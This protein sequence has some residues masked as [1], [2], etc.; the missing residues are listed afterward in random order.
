M[1]VTDAHISAIRVRQRLFGWSMRKLAREA[2][3]SVAN[4]HHMLKG[5]YAESKR[6]GG[7]LL[8]LGIRPQAERTE[9]LAD[10]R[11][12]TELARLMRAGKSAEVAQI[13]E[14]QP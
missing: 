1:K 6:L 3:L 5:R 9:L 4:L 13:L 10:D 7:V 2:G 11:A 8:A 14:A 12:V